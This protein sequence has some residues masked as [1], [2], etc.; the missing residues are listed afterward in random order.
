MPLRFVLESEQRLDAVA[1]RYQ[2]IH[3]AI[4][5]SDHLQRT[6]MLL[7]CT[8]EEAEMIRT[9][10]A[11]ERRTISGFILNAVMFHIRAR[12]EALPKLPPRK[13]EEE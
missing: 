13:K 4:A 1:T 3:N 5:M 11:L 8:R 10:A 2:L 9:A 6:A 7:R 12:S